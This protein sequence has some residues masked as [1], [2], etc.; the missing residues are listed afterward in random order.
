MWSLASY[1]VEGRAGPLLVGVQT[2]PVCL[3]TTRRNPRSLPLNYYLIGG[4]D[5]SSWLAVEALLPAQGSTKK[6]WL[7]MLGTLLASFLQSPLL[8]ASAFRPPSP[9]LAA[10]SATC[11]SR[12]ICLASG[13]QY[14]AL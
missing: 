1:S 10:E 8:L 2:N 3:G 4:Q 13:L 11:K 5:G 14:E 12:I 9:M 7:D 6:D